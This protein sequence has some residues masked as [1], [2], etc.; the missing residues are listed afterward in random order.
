MTEGQLSDNVPRPI[1]NGRIIATSVPKPE[2]S[3]WEE[4]DPSVVWHACT[5]IDANGSFILPSVPRRGVIQIIAICDGWLSTTTISEARGHFVMGQPFAL[6]RPEIYPKVE[7]ERTG[8]LE[9]MLT[10]PDGSPLE[11]AKVY[12]SPNQSHLKGGS[13]ILGSELNSLSN[14]EKQLN[15]GLEQTSLFPRRN[16]ERF[17]GTTDSNG[18]V[19]LRGIPV[20]KNESLAVSHPQYSLPRDGDR[21][22]SSVAYKIESTEPFQL[23]LKL[24]E[25]ARVP[26]SN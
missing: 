19:T 16:T 7:M 3:N 6:D 10:K 17:S 8:S 1:E 24:E 11:G 23:E 22:S 13:T 5:S 9:V 26:N 25:T 4:K 18:R 2:G 15:P 21:R 12:T 20:G 14:V